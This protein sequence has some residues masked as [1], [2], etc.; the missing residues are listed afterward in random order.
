MSILCMQNAV[1][2]RGIR[3]GSGSTVGKGAKFGVAKLGRVAA[4]DD[5]GRSAMPSNNTE[6]YRPDPGS[7]FA[8]QGSPM[9]NTTYDGQNHWPEPYE[10]E[11]KEEEPSTSAA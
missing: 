10:D 4:E 5:S 7:A 8:R 3:L 6:Y 9:V 1:M 11:V 2:G